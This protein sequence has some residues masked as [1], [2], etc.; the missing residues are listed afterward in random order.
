[1][2][3]IDNPLVAAVVEGMKDNKAHNITILDL[4]GLDGASADFFVIADGTSNTQVESIAESLVDKA[5]EELG[6]RP[7]HYE[8]RANATWI[9]VD[10]HDVV[11]HVFMPEQRAFYDIENLWSDARRQDIPDDF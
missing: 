5:R 3:K 4:R 9:L 10:Y 1:M 7:L 11:A 2:E 8:G 6:E